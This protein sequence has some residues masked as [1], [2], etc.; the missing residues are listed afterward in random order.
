MGFKHRTAECKVWRPE[1]LLY[2]ADD[3][4]CIAVTVVYDG[5]CIAVAAVCSIESVKLF[6]LMEHL[7]YCSF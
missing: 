1:L 3:G 7:S 6:L 2:L 4:L 5:I